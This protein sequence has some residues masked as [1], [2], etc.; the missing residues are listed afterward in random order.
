MRQDNSASSQACR[1]RGNEIPQAP[2]RVD[3]KLVSERISGFF[4]LGKAVLD[5]RTTRDRSIL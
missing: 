2:V 1:V 4:G 5:P 3:F